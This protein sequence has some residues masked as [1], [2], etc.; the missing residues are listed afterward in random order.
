MSTQKQ[1]SLRK[2][3]LNTSLLQ[4][5]MGLRVFYPNEAMLSPSTWSKHKPIYAGEI[6][7][8]YFICN[9]QQ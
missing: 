3:P 6:V 5:I 1:Q 2:Q 8:C 7:I 9:K 4:C